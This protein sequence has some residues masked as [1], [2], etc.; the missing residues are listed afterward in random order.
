[1][2]LILEAPNGTQL[3][4]VS[5]VAYPNSDQDGNMCFTNDAS[6]G[7]GV[8]PGGALDAL[9]WTNYPSGTADAA[10]LGIGISGNW[11]PEGGQGAFGVFNGG[12]C[13]N[14]NYDR[15]YRM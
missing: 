12:L 13:T 4:L 14:H 5:S 3:V 11:F 2:N 7:G 6:V 9:N 15:A 10:G 1:L 8:L